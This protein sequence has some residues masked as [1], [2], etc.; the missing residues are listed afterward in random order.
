MPKY[1]QFDAYR[2][3]LRRRIL[4]GGNRHPLQRLKRWW[5][6]RRFGSAAMTGEMLASEAGT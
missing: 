3:I 1:A 2:G 4:Y 5:W 6:M